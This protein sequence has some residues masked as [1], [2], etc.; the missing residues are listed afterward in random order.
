MRICVFGVGAVGGLIAA[1]IISTG[2]DV[3]LYDLP[4]RVSR[5]RSAG[6]TFI[7]TDDSFTKLSDLQFL[8]PGEKYPPFDLVFLATKSHDIQRSVSELSGMVGKST[9]IV[10]TQNGI[11]WWYFQRHGGPHEGRILRSVDP[12]GMIAGTLDP[13]QIVGCVVYPA[14]ETLTD[15]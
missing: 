13:R 9:V 12:E 11:P 10:T 2:A 6:L 4:D 14:A 3:T 1:K 8:D 5:L 15:G 7:D